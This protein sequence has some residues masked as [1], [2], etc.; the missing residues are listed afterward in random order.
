MRFLVLILNVLHVFNRETWTHIQTKFS[1]IISARDYT[2]VNRFDILLSGLLHLDRWDWNIKSQTDN[3]RTCKNSYRDMTKLKW[4]RNLQNEIRI[5]LLCLFT[6]KRHLS[7]LTTK[8]RVLSDLIWC[9]RQVVH[10][11]CV[12]VSSDHVNTG[13]NNKTQNMLQ[14]D[15]L[16]KFI[17][18]TPFIQRVNMEHTY[19]DLL[20]LINAPG[21]L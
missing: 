7:F 9:I 12:A 17:E 1:N 19:K 13:S 3:L 6:L 20:I 4:S 5:C 2:Q 18:Q 8:E 10:N 16:Y 15:V 14:K 11:L 21:A